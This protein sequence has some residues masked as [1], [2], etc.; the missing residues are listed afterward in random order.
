MCVSLCVA[1]AHKRPESAFV[2]LVHPGPRSWRSEDNVGKRPRSLLI[3]TK[4]QWI[5][6]VLVSQ[7]QNLMVQWN[8]DNNLKRARRSRPKPS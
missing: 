8:T 2:P 1:E 6:A 7:P 5:V 4:N 3:A